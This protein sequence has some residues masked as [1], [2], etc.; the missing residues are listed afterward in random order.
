M[1]VYL[2]YPGCSFV[3]R[4]QE[5]TSRFKRWHEPL[6]FKR[7]GDRHIMMINDEKTWSLAHDIFIQVCPRSFSG[8][9]IVHWIQPWIWGDFCIK[10]WGFKQAE[11]RQYVFI[12]FVTF[13]IIVST[14]CFCLMLFDIDLVPAMSTLLISNLPV[15]SNLSLLLQV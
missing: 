8:P 12:T 13:S 2:D 15:M 5:F 14:W 6:F 7:W 3:F 10:L 9:S 1:C 4:K 11:L